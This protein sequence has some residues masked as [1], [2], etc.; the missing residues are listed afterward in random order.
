MVASLLG[1]LPAPRTG[2]A[3]AEGHVV[4]SVGSNLGEETSAHL[5]ETLKRLLASAAS[6]G[7]DGDIQLV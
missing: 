5:C 6:L 4:S 3:Q 1:L 7:T 2:L